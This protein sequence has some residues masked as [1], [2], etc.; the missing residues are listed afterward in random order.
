L[1]LL[2]KKI[3]QN[4]DLD[5]FPTGSISINFIEDYEESSSANIIPNGAV[6]I[7]EL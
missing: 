1:K 3:L 5:I 2:E 6:A 4:D 7:K